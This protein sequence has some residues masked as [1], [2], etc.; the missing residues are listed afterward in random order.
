MTNRRLMSR[1]QFIKSAFA[2][3]GVATAAACGAGP[4]SAEIVIKT[5]GWPVNTMPTKE[6][7]AENPALQAYADALQTWLNRNPNV[8]LE[9][10]ETNI[11]DSA[12]ML[13]AVAGDTAPTYLFSNVLGNWSAERSRNAFALGLMADITDAVKNTRLHKQGMLPVYRQAW[14]Q[15]GQIDGR[16]FH[17]PFDA[18]LEDV[19]WYRRDLV[20]AAGL[21]EPTAD[22]NW[23]QFFDMA[24]A[25]NSD[26]VSGVGVPWHFSRDYVRSYGFD[27]LTNIP[28]PNSA[29]H[30]QRDFSDPRWAELASRYRNARFEVEG[31]Y[32]DAA[33]NNLQGYRDAFHAET[34]AMV[35]TNIMSAFKVP[36]AETSVS[37]IGRRMGLSFEETIGFARIPQG[38]GFNMGGVNLAGGVALPPNVTPEQAAAAIDLVDYIYFGDAADA[39]KSAVY[40]QTRDLQSVYWNPMPLDGNYQAAGVPGSFA[41]AWGQRTFDDLQAL[42]ALPQPP[43]RQRVGYF[44]PEGNVSPD[45]QAVDDLWSKLTYVQGALDLSAEFNS[46]ASIWNQQA[47]SFTSSI[48]GAAFSESADQYYEVMGQM[49]KESSPQFYSE[50]FVP[51]L[52]NQVRPN[53]L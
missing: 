38:D 29:W 47:E 1:R 13:T 6:A 28:S 42:I 9:R 11:W 39:Q 23:E 4:G 44:A 53:L 8:R 32:S 26:K 43:R 31:M 16:Y 22:W 18:A 5:S 20:Q 19:V 30:W 12:A 34:I 48:D 10:V 25:L 40:E 36:L 35:S 27:L 21:A 46:A 7:I 15:T 41:D 2:A 52:E 3:M 49:L 17:F 24:T 50:R 33:F 14:D 45:E 37:A 51:F